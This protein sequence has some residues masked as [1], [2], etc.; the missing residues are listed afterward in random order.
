MGK[1]NILADLHTHLNEK[2]IEPRDWWEGARKRK[3]RVVAITEHPQYDP[4]DAYLRLKAAKPKGILLIPGIEV[5]TSAGDLLVYGENES[6]YDVEEFLKKDIPVEK[7]LK[8]VKEL[9]LTAS[10]AHPYGYKHDSVCE[11]I[12]E[13]KAKAL[14]KRYK[15]G[16]EYYNGMLGSASYLVFGGKAL[17]RAYS[18]MSF[19]EKNKLSKAL[20]IDRG[21]VKA[22]TKMDK[23]AKNAVGRIQKPIIFSKNASF[24]T[25]GSDAHYPKAIGSGVIEFKQMPKNEK[26][27]ISM[28]K[29]KETLWAGPNI[30]SKN[31]VDIIGRKEILGG[32]GYLTKKSIAR[33]SKKGLKTKIGRKISLGKR[34]KTIK[35]ITKR[36]KLRKIRTK[37]P[38]I[39]KKLFRKK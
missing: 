6:I 1:K 8:K 35:R 14:I 31:P 23:I 36:V 18:I 24:I 17:K 38:K 30:Y 19:F 29:N 9:K 33:G 28:L 20:H 10:F 3:L 7:A 26:E 16:T 21:G 4:L 32:I 12:G 22:K 2:K 25:A 15:L 27:F 11:V 13:K 34:I 39:R 37:F 5:R